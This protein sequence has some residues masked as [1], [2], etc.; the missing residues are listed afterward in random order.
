M[1]ELDITVDTR[2]TR[3]QK[4]FFDVFAFKSREELFAAISEMEVGLDS[5]ARSDDSQILVYSGW[6][7]WF[8]FLK[9]YLRFAETGHVEDDNIYLD[10]LVR[11]YGPRNHDPGIASEMCEPEFARERTGTR[12]ASMQ[13]AASGAVE[14]GTWDTHP[15]LVIVR[16]PPPRFPLDVY[17]MDS[18]Q[19]FPAALVDGWHR[20]FAA[21]LWGVASLPGRVIRVASMEDAA[22]QIALAG[23]GE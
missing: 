19:P 4:L 12:F 5:L 23:S 16:V 6:V 17:A 11:Y 14:P 1:R 15:V 22:T 13:A 2:R 10:Y 9:G 3:L 7:Y 8:L 18:R 20:L 21:R